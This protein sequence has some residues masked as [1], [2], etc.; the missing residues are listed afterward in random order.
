[1]IRAE[2][3][4]L[5]DWGVHHRRLVVHLMLIL[6]A[7][8]V[9]DAVGTALIYFL[10]RN[11]NGSEVHTVFEAFFFTTVQLLTVSSQ[12]KNPVTTAGRIV[13]MFLELWAVLVV[14]GSAGAFANFVSKT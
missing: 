3:G 2:L 4:R 14:A 9:I 11:T 10:E 12:L 7:T 1:M 13:D 5:T 8:L 6:A